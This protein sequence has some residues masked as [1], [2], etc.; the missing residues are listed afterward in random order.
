MYFH[1]TN[2]VQGNMNQVGKLK[3]IASTSIYADWV[4]GIHDFRNLTAKVWANLDNSNQE[5]WLFESSGYFQM[6]AALSGRTVAGIYLWGHNSTT[7]FMEMYT[8]F[9]NFELNF[10]WNMHLPSTLILRYH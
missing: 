7:V 1:I 3:D 2:P 8:N 9:T 4:K 5:L 6:Y 10:S